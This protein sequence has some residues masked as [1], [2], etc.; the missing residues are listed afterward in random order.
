MLWRKVTEK[1]FPRINCKLSGE[2]WSVSIPTIGQ[3]SSVVMLLAKLLTYI[4]TYYSVFGKT[5]NISATTMKYTW[6]RLITWTVRHMKWTVEW[7][8]NFRELVRSSIQETGTHKASD[9]NHWQWEHVR[10]L[11]EILWDIM[12]YEIWR[13]EPTGAA[14]QQAEKSELEWTH[15]GDQAVKAELDAQ[16][17]QYMT[18]SSSSARLKSEKSIK[19]REEGPKK[20]SSGSLNNYKISVRNYIIKDS[21]RKA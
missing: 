8:M 5:R 19:G 1:K 16:F 15:G 12:M 9:V 20:R 2:L 18:S 14:R 4:H 17:D 3:R 13:Y 10:T 21:K 7:A 11:N 6:P